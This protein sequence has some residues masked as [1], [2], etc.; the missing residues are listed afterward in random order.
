MR[1]PQVISAFPSLIHCIEVDNFKKTQDELIDYVY[2][3][4]NLKIKLIF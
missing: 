4:T 1:P 3:I 2:A